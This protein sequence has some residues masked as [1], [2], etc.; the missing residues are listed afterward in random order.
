MVVAGKCG[1][2]DGS[3]SSQCDVS[4]RGSA[5]PPPS[6]GSPASHVYLHSS[7]VQDTLDVPISTRTISRRLVESGLHSQRP[8]R[9]LALT[10]Q[11]RRAR[12]EWCRA[13]VT[14][15]TEW[16]NVMFS[17]ESRFCFFKDS[18]RIREWR[19]CGERYN[20]AVTMER[21]TARQRGIMVWGAIAYDSMSPL[22]R[23][24]ST[25]NVQRCVQNVLHPMAIRYLQ[26]LSNAIFQRDNAHPHTARI[27]QH[28]LRGVQML[29][30]TAYSP[31]LSPMEHLWDVIGCRLKT[32]TLPCTND[33][34]W[35]MVEMEGRTIPQDT[36]CIL[37]D[38]V[39]RRVSS[40]IA[41]HG[42]STSY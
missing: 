28:A 18:Q 34:L 22:V 14:W 23:V 13:R 4:T 31:D 10:P 27:S 33:Q 16:R 29:P 7:D 5:Q 6:N 36:I 30:W 3:R 8:L 9:T 21:P 41:A 37:I 32:L 20:P 1:T 25:L 12:L 39:P 35:Q 26:G 40:C 2:F 11:R 17:D 38:S 19:R 15:M 24:Q 42:G